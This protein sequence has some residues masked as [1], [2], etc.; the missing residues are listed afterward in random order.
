MKI[1]KK[2]TTLKMIVLILTLIVI[3][4][5]VYG[6]Y[7]KH[8]EK[9]FMNSYS[10][11]VPLSNRTIK[12]PIQK[13]PLLYNSLTEDI[14][15]NDKTDS[16]LLKYQVSRIVPK[17]IYDNND[18]SYILLNY[19]CG[20][21]LC[22]YILVKYS[23]SHDLTCE[24]LGFG[25]YA[26]SKLSEDNK[27]IAINLEQHE[28]VEVYNNIKVVDLLSMKNQN[29]SSIPNEYEYQVISYKWINNSLSIKYKEKDSDEIVE[30]KIDSFT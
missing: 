17:I 11:E 22:D 28:D 29:L 30:K 8:N 24:Y 4:L 7:N 3:V 10:I 9:I 2:R 26:D 25:L 23:D 19:N 16:D 15:L 20:E 12:I 27:Y 14:D 18:I 6:T 1:L 13:I 21:K 5:I